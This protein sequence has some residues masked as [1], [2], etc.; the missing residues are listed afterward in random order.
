MKENL[1]T[2]IYFILYDAI[3]FI[4]VVFLLKNLMSYSNITY[5]WVLKH[6]NNI[7]YIL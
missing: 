5:I 4:E 3:P 6:I 7:F 1:P 2:K